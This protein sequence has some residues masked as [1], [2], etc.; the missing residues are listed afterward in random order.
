MHTFLLD[1]QMPFVAH[2]LV[3][4]FFSNSFCVG[5]KSFFFVLCSDFLISLQLLYIPTQSVYVCVSDD[6]GL[7]SQFVDAPTFHIDHGF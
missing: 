4:D 6:L 2:V 5:V 3:Y 1:I 7:F